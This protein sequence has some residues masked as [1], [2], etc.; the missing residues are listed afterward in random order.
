MS[1]LNLLDD[2]GRVVRNW[3]P[4]IIP[5]TAAGIKEYGPQAPRVNALVE[6]LGRMSKDSAALSSAAYDAGYDAALYV[7]E[8]PSARFDAYDAATNAAYDA[9]RYD[10][11]SAADDAVWGEVAS[12]LITPNEYLIL[13][14]PLATGRLF[15]ILRP[16]APETF[17]PVARQL[18]EMGAITSPR[19]IKLARKISELPPE[20]QQIYLNLLGKDTDPIQL[21]EAVR[22]MG[23]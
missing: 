17:T 16:N 11:L 7:P 9:A 19:S 3:G 1:L 20:I 18:G 6:G 12:D 13:T 2:A 15:D 4:K 22:L 21:L 5:A 14:R 10:P 23:Q 8:F